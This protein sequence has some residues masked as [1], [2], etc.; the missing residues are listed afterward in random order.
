MSELNQKVYDQA[1]K[2]LAIRPHTVGE[3]G[4]K[5]KNRRFADEAINPVLQ[6]LIEQKF[7]DD[8]RFAEIFVDNL[9]RYKDWGYYGVKARLL[10][11]RIPSGI[12]EQA[13]ADF[14]TLPEEA[15][16][17]HRLIDKLKKRGRVGR[18]QIARSL[19]S[20][21]FRSKVIGETLKAAD[22]LET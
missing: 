1:T 18:E 13:L 22:N 4:Q 12:L 20:R 19:Q 9:K 6:K 14:F 7:L 16:V 10:A 2:L 17:A 21:G 3:L 15:V 8:Q 11:R 5:L